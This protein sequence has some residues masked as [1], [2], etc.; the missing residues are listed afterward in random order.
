MYYRVA[1]QVDLSPL[2]QWK[3]TV[4]SSLDALFQW[5][6]LYRALP[7]DRLRVF[8]SSSSKDM[9]EQLAR[10]NMGYGSTSVTVAKFLHERMIGSREVAWG[11]SEPGT[12]GNQGTASIA[13]AT[14]PSL[15][16]SSRGAHALD[17]GG[18]SSLDRRRLELER[19]TGGD[20]DVPYSF[21]LPA[22]LPQ[23]LTWMRLLARVQRGELQ[24]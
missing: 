4:L 5:L 11:A 20:H 1:I 23:V 22:S 2:W 10:E 3:S 16:E 19:G 7:Q 24:P 12:W 9:N 18:M 17:E 21:A 13:V 15:N 8:S 14:N 6:R